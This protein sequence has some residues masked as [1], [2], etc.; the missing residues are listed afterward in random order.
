MKSVC[1]LAGA[2]LVSGPLFAQISVYECT[3]E[4]SLV[5]QQE[6]NSNTAEIYK[7]CLLFQGQNYNLVSNQA[8]TLQAMNVIDFKSGFHGKPTG[9]GFIH[10][11]VGNKGDFDVVCMNYPN[12]TSALKYEKLEF[13]ITLPESVQQRVDNFINSVPVPNEQSLNP[14][15][16]WDI[17]ISVDF[18]HQQIP[19]DLTVDAFYNKEYNEW[20][21]GEIPEQVPEGHYLENFPFNDYNGFYQSLGGYVEEPTAYPFLARFSPPRVG[22]WK[23]IV[24]MYLGNGEVYAS[25]PFNFTVVD[26]DNK[27]YVK[28]SDD[29]RTFSLGGEPFYPLGA[30]ILW[31]MTSTV[32]NNPGTTSPELYKLLTDKPNANNP[33]VLD[34]LSEDYRGVKPIPVLYDNYRNMIR[35]IADGGGNFARLIMHPFSSDIEFERL[36]DYSKRLH[37]AQELDEVLE[38]SESRNVY[39]DWNMMVHYVLTDNYYSIGWNNNYNGKVFDYKSL[40]TVTNPKDF[41]SSPEAKAYFK[42]KIRYVIS[43]WGYSTHIAMLELFSEI[44]NNGN[45]IEDADIFESWHSEMAQYLKERYNGV[46]HLVQPS[47]TGTINNHDQT[48]GN[49]NIDVVTTNFY[50]GSKAYARTWIDHLNANFLNQKTIE[51][52]THPMRLCSNV[53][54]NGNYHL[55][56]T[57]II[58]PFFMPEFDPGGDVTDIGNPETCDAA[59]LDVRRAMWQVPFTGAAGGLSWNSY[60]NGV[61]YSEFSKIRTFMEN[62]HG[63]GGWHPGAM[64]LV[65]DGRWEYRSDWASEM[66]GYEKRADLSYLRSNDKN[67]AIGVITNKTVNVYSLG[68]SCGNPEVKSYFDDIALL[69]LFNVDDLGANGTIHTGDQDLYLNGLK[70]GR[71]YITYFYPGNQS[72]PYDSDDNLGP[73]I[74]LETTI[75]GF[76]NT[77]IVL[78]MARRT[79]SDWLPEIEDSIQELA[80]SHNFVSKT[81]EVDIKNETINQAVD[82]DLSVYPIPAREKIVLEA[83]QLVSNLEV[84]I[85]SSEGKIIDK[86][87]MTQT[88]EEVDI[89]QYSK[90][91]YIVKFYLS[92]NEIEQKKIVKL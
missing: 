13:G 32:I 58:K 80:D 18:T 54:Y 42:Q 16:D 31:P 75:P 52:T 67:Y 4:N 69:D 70:N 55:E 14:F 47:Y 79:G 21:I 66:D 83:S 49:A 48:Y 57:K 40:Q 87:D 3:P 63:K 71:Y 65:N 19:Y 8:K 36:G 64:E 82:L 10:L 74:K 90:G 92:G 50:V 76:E 59:M 2:V 20:M 24:R 60:K 30:N 73:R 38:Y 78:F 7:P 44:N 11:K 9:N 39:L 41:F 17:R 43:R 34:F 46:I 45:S 23:C 62:M 56:C 72:T 89:S 88:S 61:V 51:N 6:L 28:V 26:S 29:Q 86:L 91:V 81:V 85:V 35:N 84:K 77:Y 53:F 27:G 5:S 12:L 33:E 1:F 22:K 25:D 15:M 68:G 37:I